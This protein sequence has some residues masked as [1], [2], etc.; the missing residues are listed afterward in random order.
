MMKA[1]VLRETG[2][3]VEEIDQPAC[4]P[5]EA[6]VKL[7]FAALNHRD[8]WIR[9]GLYAGIRHP[10]VLGSDGMGTVAAVGSSTEEHWVGRKVVIN[11]NINW[12]NSQAH[13]DMSSYQILGM[14]SQ[15]TL[16]EYVKVKLDRLHEMPAHLLFQEAAALPLAGLT[17]FNALF[18]KG[19]VSKGMNV[20]ISGVGGGVAQMAFQF[21]LAAKAEVWVT[22]SKEAVISACRS[23]GAAGGANYLLPDFHK[24]LRAESGGFDC[25][26]DSAGG[27]GMND[28]LS[29][30]MPGGR[31]VF[32]GATRGLPSALNMRMIFWKHLSLL[33]TTMGSD[34]DF[35]D[36]LDF[37]SK[38]RIHPLIDRVF[39]LEE[40]P[41]AFDR[42]KEGLQ[43]G[44]IVVEC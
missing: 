14:P 26:I 25:I 9:E 42:M 15:G 38:H 28:L 34:K 27:D 44:K 39:T 18:N 12:G 7:R 33:G 32:F 6:L 24:Q 19:S 40:A 16:A 22:S 17:A 8:Q 1:L 31:Y 37:V 41:E 29:A 30:L 4:A 3:K 21:A 23:M 11:P 36:M 13:Q 10:A 5:G 43:F 2:L 20:L 35:R